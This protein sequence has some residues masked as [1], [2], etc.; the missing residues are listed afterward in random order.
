MASFKS[1]SSGEIARQFHLIQALLDFPLVFLFHDQLL[2]ALGNRPPPEFSEVWTR[3]ALGPIPFG[4]SMLWSLIFGFL[5]AFLIVRF[6]PRRRDN[7][8]NN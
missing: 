3:G 8:R 1:S 4:A 6:S 2:R 7:T 5:V